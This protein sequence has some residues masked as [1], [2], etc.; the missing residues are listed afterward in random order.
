MNMAG[1]VTAAEVADMEQAAESV[2][3][4]RLRELGPTDGDQML[5]SASAL[6]AILRSQLLLEVE[7]TLK[8]GWWTVSIPLLGFRHAGADVT[9]ATRAGIARARNWAEERTDE[10]RLDLAVWIVRCSDDQT[11]AAWFGLPL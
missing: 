2:A 9:E 5:V 4:T 11:L 6:S 10:N 1:V 3:Q 7:T 8:D